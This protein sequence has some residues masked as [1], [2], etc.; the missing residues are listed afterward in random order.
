MASLLSGNDAAVRVSVM[1]AARSLPVADAIPLLRQATKDSSPLVRK[2]VI[3][4]VASWPAADGTSSGVPLLRTLVGGLG[5]GDSL[6]GGPAD[7]AACSES[8]TGARRGRGTTGSART[9]NDGSG[10]CCRAGSGH[11][12]GSGSG[13]DA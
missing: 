10:R 12:G 13:G 7:G 5:R 4:V 8:P 3:E 9:R 2:Q 1:E 6:A 11:C